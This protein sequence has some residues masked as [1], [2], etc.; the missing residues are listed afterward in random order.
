[1]DGYPG[2]TRTSIHRLAVWVTN[3]GRERHQMSGDGG[4]DALARAAGRDVPALAVDPT[5]AGLA[6]KALLERVAQLKTKPHLPQA[7]GLERGDEGDDVARLQNY[8]TQFGYLASPIAE[9]F[10]VREL[11]EAPPDEFGK[12]DDQTLSALQR[13]QQFFGLPVTGRLDE[14]TLDSMSRPRCGFPDVTRP[15]T[16]T[17]RSPRERFVL[18]G[19]KWGDNPVRWA[20]ENVTSDLTTDQCRLAIQAAF[21]IWSNVSSLNFVESGNNPHLRIRFLSG[22]HG[23]AQAFDGS[24]GW[25][26]HAYNPGQDRRGQVHFDEGEA[27]SVT[28]GTGTDLITVA[29]HEFGHA[30]GLDHTDDAKALM[31][32]KYGSR[33]RSLGWDD[34]SG[35]VT[36]YGERPAP[37]WHGWGPLHGVIQGAPGV[38]ISGQWSD[39]YVRGT[40]NALHQK[41]SDTTAWS[42]WHRHNDGAVLTSE[43]VVVS[44]SLS[45]RD[46]YIRG[47]DGAVWHKWWNGGPWSGWERIGGQIQGRPGVVVPPGG[48]LTDVY[49]RGMDNALWQNFWDPS[50]GWSGWFRHTDGAV[51]SAP[52]TVVSTGSHHRDVYIRGT[53][54]AVWHK[55]WNGKSWSGWERLGGEIQGPPGVVALSGGPTDVYVRGMDNVLWQ[56]YRASSSTGWSD[57][58]KLDGVLTSSPTAVSYGR[59]HRAIYVRGTDGAVHHKGWGYRIG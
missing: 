39:V 20:F 32:P 12:F 27:W 35:I 7:P 1:M 5:Q 50:R 13:Y 59:D 47:T 10:G 37:H 26:A 17:S 9:S 53:D 31:W 34:I 6:N 22:A 15:A 58:I 40:D 55:W 57:W 21:Y 48:T 11:S 51:L 56:K 46:V 14:E 36:L 42:D 49:A 44:N 25:L 29:T 4:L 30:L 33:Y 54:G 23:C 52:P 28:L 41:W 18:Y 16:S 45:H 38:V 8:L 24:G 3:D 19:K 2:E 43:P